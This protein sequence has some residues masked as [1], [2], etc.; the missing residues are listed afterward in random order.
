MEEN[1]DNLKERLG[2]TFVDKIRG[3]ID[4]AIILTII[5]AASFAL[6]YAYNGGYN[7]YYGIPLFLTS[8]S[9]SRFMGN[10]PIISLIGIFFAGT[11]I[12]SA[13]LAHCKNKLFNQFMQFFG[14]MYIFFAGVALIISLF[15]LFYL[16]S[17]MF[18]IVA[19]TSAV[20]IL[21]I[22]YL[23]ASDNK[24]KKW[25]VLAKKK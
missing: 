17:L 19:I 12:I 14:K 6:F 20:I 11:L 22:L 9:P 8:T 18:G 10:L 7:Y 21:V 2:D 4:S 1:R 16:K 13:T 5:T 25:T 3:Y 15:L 23:N 24:I